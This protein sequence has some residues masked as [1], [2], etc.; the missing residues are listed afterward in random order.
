MIITDKE[1]A[2]IN[3]VLFKFEAYELAATKYED[4]HIGVVKNI[5]DKSWNSTKEKLSDE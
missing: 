2:L 4:C 5:I 1:I 3:E